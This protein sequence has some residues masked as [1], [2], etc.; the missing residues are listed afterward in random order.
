[1]SAATAVQG[2]LDR[3]YA[4]MDKDGMFPSNWCCVRCGKQLNADGHHPAELYAGTYNGMCYRCTLGPKFLEG[5]RGLDGGNVWNHPPHC[6][7]WRRDREKHVFFWDCEDCHGEG[8]RTSWNNAA[9]CDTCS[10]RTYMTGTIHDHDAFRRRARDAA[11]AR[12]ERR[13]VA[14]LKLPKRISKKRRIEALNA[15]KEAEPGTWKAIADRTL[16]E[17]KPVDEAITRRAERMGTYRVYSADE[18]VTALLNTLRF[19]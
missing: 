7:S 2:L 16:A 8:R 15:L 12:F 19:A 18:I 1:M 10:K 17:W 9:R 4:D 3:A 6:P 13:M 11:Q 14:H 5:T